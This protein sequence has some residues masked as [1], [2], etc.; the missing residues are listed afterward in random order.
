MEDGEA[1]NLAA[2]S[3]PRSSN[4]RLLEHQRDVVCAGQAVVRVIGERHRDHRAGGTSGT[5]PVRLRNAMSVPPIV[6][7]GPIRIAA[8]VLPEASR[9][10]ARTLAMFPP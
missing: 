5:L 4:V 8:S 1:L 9:N 7:S 10:A 3:D 6:V 2:S